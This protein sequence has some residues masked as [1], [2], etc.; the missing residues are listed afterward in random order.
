MGKGLVGVGGVIFGCWS[1]G[2]VF[3]RSVGWCFMGFRRYFE[4]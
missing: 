4:L 3:L 1:F 2:R